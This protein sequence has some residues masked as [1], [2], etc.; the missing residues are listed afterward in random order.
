[1]GKVAII[2]G[3]LLAFLIP[4][5]IVVALN[6]DKLAGNAG[7]KANTTGKLVYYYAPS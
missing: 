7:D 5:G 1:M 3:A 6:F 4:I 2:I